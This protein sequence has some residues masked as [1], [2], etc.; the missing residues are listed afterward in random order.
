MATVPEAF[1]TNS[2]DGGGCA[3]VEDQRYRSTVE[4]S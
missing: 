4:I 1:M 3:D 2:G